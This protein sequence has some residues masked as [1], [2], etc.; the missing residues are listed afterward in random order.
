MSGLST[1]AYAWVRLVTDT[2]HNAIL[3]P[4]N[5]VVDK[6]VRKYVFVLR[7]P[8]KEQEPDVQEAQ[9][10]PPDEGGKSE[11]GDGAQAKKDMAAPR[12]SA[13]VAEQVEVKVGLEDSQFVEIVDGIEADALVV[14]MGQHTL[15]HGQPRSR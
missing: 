9:A 8:T 15:K 5:A 4:K 3:L 14:T 11:S 1:G 12:S 6:N 10:P 13:F 2:H 7:E